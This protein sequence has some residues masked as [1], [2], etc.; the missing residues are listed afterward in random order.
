MLEYPRGG[1]F[2]EPCVAVIEVKKSM[3]NTVTSQP[4][5]FSSASSS[6]AESSLNDKSR[7]MV[8]CRRRLAPR[9]RQTQRLNIAE[10]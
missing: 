6:S 2:A 3:H 4:T 7:Y 8:V 1:Q 5:A 9:T 10:A